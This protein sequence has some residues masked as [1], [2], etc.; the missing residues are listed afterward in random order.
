MSA[1]Q[2]MRKT[3]FWLKAIVLLQLIALALGVRQIFYYRYQ[4]E[5]YENWYYTSQW[6][7]PGSSRGISDGE[8]YKFVGYRLAQGENPFYLNYEAPP[9]AKY[10]YG[11]TAMYLGNPY[12]ATWAWLLLSVGLMYSLLRWLLG[13]S[14]LVWLGLWLYLSNPFVAVNA[15]ETMLDLP[16][17][18]VL[19]LHGWAMVRFS[20]TQKKTYLSLAGAALGLSAA[21]KFG[22]YAPPIAM[23][24]A[25]WLKWGNKWWR[26]FKQVVWFGFSLAAGYVFGYIDYFL[27][28]P[29]PIPWLKLHKAQISFYIG[30]GRWQ[31][32][33]YLSQWRSIFGGH[34][35][36]WWQTD[37]LPMSEWS[38]L[39][40]IG[41]VAV[42]AVGWW[43]WRQRDRVWLYLTGLVLVL[44]AVNS[45]LSFFPRYLLVVFP[46]LVVMVVFWWRRHW[47]WIFWLIMLQLPLSANLLSQHYSLGH[48]HAT[49]RFI[50]TRADHELYRSIDPRIR[51]SLPEDEFVKRI[52]QTFDQLGVRRIETEVVGLRS[53]TTQQAE[54]D[55]RLAYDTKFGQLNHAAV[56]KYVRYQND[57]RVDWRWDYL[58]PGWQSDSQLIAQPDSIAFWRMVDSKGQLLAQRGQ[59]YMVYVRQQ[60]MYDW[61]QSLNL[62][63]ELTGLTGLEVD[64][65]VKWTVPEMKLRYVGYL[66]HRLDLA[67]VKQKVDNSPAVELVP[68]QDAVV[69]AADRDYVGSQINQLHQ[70]RPALFYL[71]GQVGWQIGGSFQP[72]EFQAVAETDKTVQI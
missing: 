5:Y 58:L 72:F 44:L 64:Q 2:W 14:S 19:L 46:W 57:W 23:L 22:V 39:L 30:D 3:S 28:H 15:R 11:L 68:I 45:L 51:Q 25:V 35:S 26:W 60:Q 24:A 40:P 41:V 34:Y 43:A 42:I 6:N 66:D 50:S 67:N 29:N 53:R 63:S 27:S 4:P 21:I 9:F 13:R 65:R 37:S 47:Q 48:A 55:L 71:R 31:A 32:K 54:V 20:Q 49:A 1:K 8:L 70:T 10:V 56:V 33:D 7:I 52:E 61:N 36:A 18:T 16:L 69:V 12:L 17:M 38:L 59:W 62:M